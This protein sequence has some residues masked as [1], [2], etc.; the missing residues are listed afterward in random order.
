MEPAI[1]HGMTNANHRLLCQLILPNKIMHD[2]FLMRWRLIELE[3]L[4]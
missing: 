2:S 3:P 1:E 4:M